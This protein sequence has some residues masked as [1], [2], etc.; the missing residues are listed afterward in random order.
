MH[1]P[2]NSGH[3]LLDV[4]RRDELVAEPTSSI[5]ELSGIVPG[6]VQAFWLDQMED[7]PFVSPVSRRQVSVNLAWYASCCD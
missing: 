4:I 5:G 6:A 7:Q 1:P 3:C 2:S